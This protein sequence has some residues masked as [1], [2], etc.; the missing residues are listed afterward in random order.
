[1]SDKE[2]LDNGQIHHLITIYITKCYFTPK[3]QI[4]KKAKWLPFLHKLSKNAQ[5]LM[6]SSKYMY[7]TS[8][9]I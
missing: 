1:M 9:K 4:R 7:K 3:S 6:R 5:K 8:L 2:Y